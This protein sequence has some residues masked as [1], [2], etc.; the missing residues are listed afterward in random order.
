MPGFCRG[1]DLE[2]FQLK[3]NLFRITFDATADT[4]HRKAQAG[5]KGARERA[6]SVVRLCMDEME[7][8]IVPLATTGNGIEAERIAD[9]LKKIDH[10]D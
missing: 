2:Q 9:L 3:R 4:A 6:L 1:D 8:L 10:M 7:S 5:A